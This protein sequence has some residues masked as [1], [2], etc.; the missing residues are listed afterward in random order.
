MNTNPRCPICDHKN[1]IKYIV[2][3]KQFY[4]R[5]PGCKT[6]FNRAGDILSTEYVSEIKPVVG[7]EPL[8]MRK[9]H[10]SFF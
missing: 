2:R 7:H 8:G 10:R 5:K 4:C 9:F 6:C 1:W 3:R